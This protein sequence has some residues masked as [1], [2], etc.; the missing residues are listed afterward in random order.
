VGARRLAGEGSDEDLRTWRRAAAAVAQLL[1]HARD[2]RGEQK[3][4]VNA[5]R[6]SRGPTR[7]GGRRRTGERAGM[8]EEEDA[9]ELDLAAPLHCI[10]GRGRGKQRLRAKQRRVGCKPPNPCS[11]SQTDSLSG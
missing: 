3:A 10:V 4:E 5:V 8:E 2:K 7:D 1:S 11:C 6:G 9:Q